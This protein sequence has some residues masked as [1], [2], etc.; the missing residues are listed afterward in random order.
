MLNGRRP[1]QW[2]SDARP[3]DNEFLA[4]VR[5]QIAEAAP[6]MVRQCEIRDGLMVGLPAWSV[7]MLPNHTSSQ[8]HFDIGFNPD[9]EAGQRGVVTDCLSGLGPLREAV[10]QVLRIWLET[11]GA[12]FLE[13]LTGDGRFADHLDGA[14]P[15]G[16]PG[17]LAITSPITGYSY[18]GDQAS[19]L[20]LR[21]AMGRNA[22][23]NRL[24]GR[25]RPLL[26][27]P[28]NNGIKF[29]YF[30]KPDA[31]IAEVRVNGVADPAASQALAE[32]DWPDVSEPAIVRYYA[33]ATQPG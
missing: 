23:L 26:T 12:C 3:T 27:K 31:A 17:W 14:E 33:V 5:D 30:K 16:L 6:T 32:L 11:S 4:L 24:A 18:G 21:D 29:F 10:G 8:G 2:S 15:D 9:L 19:A 22:V 25:L 13:M 28:V 1:G 7:M 20:A